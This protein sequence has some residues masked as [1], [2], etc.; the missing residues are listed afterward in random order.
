MIFTSAQTPIGP[1]VRLAPEYDGDEQLTN[2]ILQVRVRGGAISV[3]PEGCM[4]VTRV[5]PRPI[6]DEA[7][8]WLW[9]GE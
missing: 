7:E 2:A 1:A 9:G 6:Q 4:P 3:K 8:P 5:F